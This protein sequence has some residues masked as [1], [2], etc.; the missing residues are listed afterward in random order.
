MSELTV[1]SRVRAI[2]RITNGYGEG[3]RVVHPGSEGTVRTFSRAK[4]YP[5][6]EWDAGWQDICRPGQVQVLDEPA[7]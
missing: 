3:Q 5:V 7:A 4:G 1:G 2:A 6:V